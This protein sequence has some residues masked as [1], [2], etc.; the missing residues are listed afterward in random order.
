MDVYQQ[1]DVGVVPVLTQI[2]RDT[3]GNPLEANSDI[4]LNKIMY[5]YGGRFGI[6]DVPESFAYGKSGKYFIDSSDKKKKN[7]QKLIFLN[8]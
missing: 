2:V 7:G 1:F 6:G 4:L 8:I 3:A 5:P